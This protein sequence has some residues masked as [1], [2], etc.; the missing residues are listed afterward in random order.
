MARSMIEANQYVFS[1]LIKW[2]GL[3]GRALEHLNKPRWIRTNP[4]E[5]QWLQHLEVKKTEQLTAKLKMS[6]VTFEERS[7]FVVIGYSGAVQMDYVLKPIEMNAGLFTALA[8]ELKIPIGQLTNPLEIIE[9][10]LAQFD[11][12]ENYS[13]HDFE[14]VQMLFDPVLVYEIERDSPIPPEQMARLTCFWL[15]Q[16]KERIILPFSTD[17]LEVMENLLASGMRSLPSEIFLRS[18]QCAHWQHAFLEVYRCI[19]RL[20]SFQIVD[21]LHKQLSI[22]I[23]LLD[24]A[25]KIEDITGWRPREQDAIAKLFDG[26]PERAK[27]LLE[28]VRGEV[29]GNIE[30]KIP[31]WVY[32]LRNS[33]VHFRPATRQFSLT[34]EQWDRIVRGTI[35]LIEKLYWKYDDLLQAA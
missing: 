33:V 35:L 19:E 29:G 17:T 7:F 9:S 23:S 28:G 31:G 1:Q 5:K 27:V 13:G 4:E 6:L 18:L 10:T 16:S 25:A 34:D 11:G 12:V 20:F 8:K 24:F 32:D 30:E 3:S 14:S 21:E 15:L 26:V 2:A 22:S